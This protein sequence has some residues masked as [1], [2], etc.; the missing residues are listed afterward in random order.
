MSL[1]LSNLKLCEPLAKQTLPLAFSMVSPTLCLPSTVTS[2]AAFSTSTALM[3]HHTWRF[4]YG[5]F[6]L[7]NP[8]PCNAKIIPLEQSMPVS[9]GEPR[10]GSAADIEKVITVVASNLDEDDPKIHPDWSKPKPHLETPKF[11]G[12]YVVGEWPPKGRVYWKLPFKVKLQAGRIYSWCS[13]GLSKNSPFC[14]GSHKELNGPNFERPTNP[15]FLPT[16]FRPTETKEYWLC[17]CKQTNNRPFC[18]G[19]HRT[20]E[21]ITKLT[22]PMITDGQRIKIKIDKDEA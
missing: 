10:P 12:E 4:Y 16:K 14:D 8:I 11:P 18:D 6:K 17:Q 19:T 13:C 20:M 22:R 7:K 2:A 15:R 5:K 1:I 21:E 3:P 9:D